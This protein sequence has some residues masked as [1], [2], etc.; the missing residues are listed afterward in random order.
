MTALRRQALGD[1]ALDLLVGWRGEIMR[2]A[3]K[4]SQELIESYATR[5]GALLASLEREAADLQASAYSIGHI[6]VGCAVAYLDFRYADF[7]WRAD[8]PQLAAW[9]AA[10]SARPA[11]RATEPVDDS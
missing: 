6:A 10:F 9:Y 5:R 8:H 1:G 4:R 7:A 2:P 11:V 3:E